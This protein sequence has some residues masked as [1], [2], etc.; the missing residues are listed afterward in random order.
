MLEEEVVVVGTGTMIGDK[1]GASKLGRITWSIE[2]RQGRTFVRSRTV[3]P[4]G[5]T[6]KMVTVAT[7]KA[8]KYG[9]E[10]PVPIL[11]QVRLMAEVTTREK[12]Q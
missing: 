7:A 6:T 1:G 2:R 5:G 10:V 4:R 3:A 8:A 9:V 12:Y 11:L